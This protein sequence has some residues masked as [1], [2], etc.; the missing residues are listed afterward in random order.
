MTHRPFTIGIIAGSG[1]EAGMDLW[2]K[3]LVQ[4][5]NQ[6]GTTFRG[7]LDAPRV[8]IVSEPELGLSMDLR[9]N[10]AA[11]WVAL[12]RTVRQIAP[13]VDVFVIACN[14]LNWFAPRI[15]ALLDTLPN[16]GQ[17]LSFQAVL[18][19]VLTQAGHNH[20]GLLAAGPVMALD[21]WSAYAE[22]QSDIEFETAN[23][24]EELHLLIEDVKRFGQKHVGLEARFQSIAQ[25]LSSEIVIL[26][27]TELPLIATPVVGKTL[28]DV[29]DCVAQMLAFRA[30]RARKVSV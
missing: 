20:V 19:Q 29:T 3:L 28:I 21:N 7:D 12:D 22:L 27:C 1:P 15:Q 16:V 30:Y 18:H 23:Q 8:V 14:T 10:E 11:T 25:N 26:A 9:V 24:S 6:F 17:F 13:Q 4:T 2:S 5:Q